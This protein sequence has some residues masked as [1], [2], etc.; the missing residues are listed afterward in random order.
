LSSK[1]VNTYPYHFEL[2]E[3][4]ATCDVPISDADRTK[5]FQSNAENVFGLL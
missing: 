1:E 4:D 3:V 2:Y 5:L